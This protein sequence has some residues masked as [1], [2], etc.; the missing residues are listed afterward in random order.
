MLRDDERRALYESILDDPEASHADRLRADE[1]LQELDLPQRV[2][3]GEAQAR[4]SPEQQER[5]LIA[6]GMPAAIAVAKGPQFIHRRRS[7]TTCG[8]CSPWRWRSTSA[9]KR[10]SLSAREQF[11]A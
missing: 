2:N 8:K 10:F 9:S 7:R 4:L 3:A 1:R 11:S 6:F 5:A